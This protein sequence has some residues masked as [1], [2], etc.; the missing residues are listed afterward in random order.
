MLLLNNNYQRSVL[1]IIIGGACLSFLGIGVRLMDQ[2]TSFQ[3][4]FYR[5]FTQ[6]VF[7]TVIIFIRNASL[8]L[9]FLSQASPKTFVISSL[10][11]FAGLF[12]VLAVQHTTVA[13]AV[14]IISLAPLTSALLGKL[15]LSE[16]VSK[17][18]WVSIGIA[19]IGV[20]IIFADGYTAGGGLL[21]MFFALLMMLFY[22]SSLV[23]VRSQKGADMFVICALSGAF[24]ALGIFPFINDFS[25][26]NHDLALCAF[27]GVGQVGLG[28]L[29]ITIGAEHVP[30]A[31]VSLLA[32]LEVVL[33]PVWVWIGVGEVPSLLS[34][35]GGGIVLIGVIL[36]TLQSSQVE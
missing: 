30:T 27:L 4:I 18:T 19:I 34:L 22:S 26:S 25:I 16:M 35:L 20:S 21:G 3:I 6:A 17:I 28:L 23:T 7:F 33:S 29:L 24:L 14:F 9:N 13:N 11:G 10:L 2:A 36:Q 8:K 31:Q 32:L 1:F 12:M 15:F 5:G